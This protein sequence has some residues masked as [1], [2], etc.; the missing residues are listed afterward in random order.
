M[1]KEQI[2]K[3]WDEYIKDLYHDERDDIYPWVNMV[4]PSILTRVVEWD[5][6]NMKDGKATVPDDVTKELKALTWSGDDKKNV[7]WCL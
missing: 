3:G 7:K 4:G 2:M 6:E 1:D 5:T